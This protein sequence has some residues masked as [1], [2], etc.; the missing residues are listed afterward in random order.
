[1]G[2]KLKPS[3]VGGEYV[4]YE[5]ATYRPPQKMSFESAKRI[6]D[7]LKTVEEIGELLRTQVLKNVYRYNDPRAFSIIADEYLQMVE[8]LRNITADIAYPPAGIL[9]N[10]DETEDQ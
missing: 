4:S 2:K 10:D 5:Y 9:K 7:A 8:D 1:M 6:H 3:D